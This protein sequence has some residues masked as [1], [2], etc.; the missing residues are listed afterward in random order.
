MFLCVCV[1]LS[2]SFVCFFC[3]FLFYFFNSFTCMQQSNRTGK[4]I[5]CRWVHASFSP[6]ILPA[7][8]VKG[9]TFLL[10]IADWN[11]LC[12]KHDRSQSKCFCVCVFF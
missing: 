8:A 5:V 1:F 12:S 10:H 4:Y 6:E 9:L 11:L 2:Q 7:G 3:F